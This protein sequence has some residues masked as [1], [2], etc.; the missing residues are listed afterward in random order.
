MWA[1]LTD[2]SKKGNQWDPDEFF[3]T[4]RENALEAV[5]LLESLCIPVRFGQALDFG[6]GLGR[7][8]QGLAEHFGTV[9]GVDIST[10]MIAGAKRW[11]R[12]GERCVFIE[13][14]R[15][16]LSLF[17][18]ETFDLCYSYIVL[19]H[20]PQEFA[21][22]YLR[23]FVRVLRPGGI[24]LFQLPDLEMETKPLHYRE[25]TG[26]QMEMFGTRIEKVIALF[27]E[28]NCRLLDLREDGWAGP[29]IP[30]YRYCFRKV[31]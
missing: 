31:T 1:V 12:H 7:L 11:N 5:N 23:E 18:S 6:C 25:E 30:S 22:S 9:V 16:D 3:R 2:E 19:Q 29:D 28:L 26:G 8:T 4:G 15:E 24:C 14:C 27:R 21:Q 10:S 17:E 20:M 13:N